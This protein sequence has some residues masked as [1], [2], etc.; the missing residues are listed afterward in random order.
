[1]CSAT[2]G[3]RSRTGAG[4]LTDAQKPEKSEF[5]AGSTQAALVISWDLSVV[6]ACSPGSIPVLS[7]EFVTVGWFLS[8]DQHFHGIPSFLCHSPRLQ[9]WLHQQDDQ[10]KQAARLPVAHVQKPLPV[11]VGLVC[12]PAALAV[13]AGPLSP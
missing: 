9:P 7:P 3:G 8:S 4:S 10:R 11:G 12:R 1:M 6:G 5:S 13:G 2:R